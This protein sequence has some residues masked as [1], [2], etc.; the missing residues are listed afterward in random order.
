MEHTGR[1]GALAAHAERHARFALAS[2]DKLQTELGVAW[3]ADL[4]AL[5]EQLYADDLV[6]ENAVKGYAAFAMDAMR[7]QKR[8]ERERSYEAKSHAQAASEVYLNAAYMEQKY[9]PGLLLSHFLW[10]HHY[11]QLQFFRGFF[12]DALARREARDFAEVGVGTGVY[13]RVFLDRVASARGMGFDISPY[14]LRFA[15]R[16]IAAFGHAAR[17][18]IEERDVIAVPTEQQFDA[19][20]CVEVLEH[21]E[22][23]VALLRT[24]RAMTA[25]S[26]RLFVTAA[27]NSAHADHIY[28]YREPSEVVEHAR[29]A[30]LTLLSMFCVNAYVSTSG[31][32]PPSAVAM[33]LCPQ[34]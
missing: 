13:S 19:V 7:R 27:L 4:N 10:Q 2:L 22:D 14:A 28:L 26:G 17:Y 24:L 9:L 31:A 29:Q 21:L 33:V 12:V 25:P 11:A 34:G 16:H 6:L 23:P 5:L 1:I 3:R 30:G 32:P 15:Q 20:L 8:F 18:E